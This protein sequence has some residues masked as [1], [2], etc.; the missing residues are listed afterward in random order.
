MGSPAACP[1][2]A[3]TTRPDGPTPCPRASEWLYSPPLTA[4]GLRGQVVVLDFWTYTCINWLRTLGYVRAW[5][6]RYRDDGVVVVGVHTPEFPFEGDV[7]NVRRA[8]S[9]M[10]IDH[11]VALDTDYA[12]WRALQQ[13][14]LARAVHR[15]CRGTDPLSP[16]RRLPTT[17]VSGDP[18][19]AARG[20][21][22]ERL[23]RPRRDLSRRRRGA[24]RLGEPGVRRRPISATTR[25]GTLPT[26][27][28]VP[29]SYAL[30][31]ELP[32]NRW[33]LAGEW[34]IE[35]RASVLNEVEGGI[36]FRFHARDV[37]LV[38]R[39]REGTQ[40]PFRAILDGE[41]PGRRTVSTSTARA[42]GTLVEP[43]LYQLVRQPGQ[44]VDRTFGNHLQ[45]SGG[46]GIRVHR[47]R[48]GSQSD[49]GP[50]CGPSRVPRT[51]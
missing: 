22:G 39:S 37:N 3:H 14:L 34:T 51:G 45:R 35:E 15:R 38:I 48:R 7:E 17:S 5:A 18:E 13:P 6:E 19:P 8:V 4:A 9:A 16:L 49:A 47:L 42:S 21:L 2:G 27:D 50:A 33:A 26:G 24:G 32:R 29:R 44:V 28:D 10:R 23:R 30:P 1:I 36:A 31:D 46:R 11:P 43:R 41:A 40:I 25:D 12:V 20:G